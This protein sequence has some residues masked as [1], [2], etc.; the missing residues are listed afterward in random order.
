MYEPITLADLGEF[1]QIVIRAFDNLLLLSFTLMITFTI[2]Y[3]LKNL[4]LGD[5]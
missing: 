5:R 4:F 3:H 1:L 2:M